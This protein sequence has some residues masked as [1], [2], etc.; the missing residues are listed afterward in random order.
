MPVN[1]VT[2]DNLTADQATRLLG[3]E[4]KP[5]A[6]MLLFVGTNAEGQQVPINNATASFI[7]TGSENLL[8]TCAHVVHGFR[9]KR[10]SDPEL[11]MAIGG[12]GQ[13]GVLEIKQEWLVDC[14][15]GTDLKIDLATYRLLDVGALAAFGKSCFVTS[16]WPP[17]KAREGELAVIA[18]FPGEH[19]Q[20]FERRMIAN[21]N[22]IADPITSV[23]ETYFTLAD[24]NQERTLVK[25]NESLGSLGPFGG[26]SGSA[27]YVVDSEGK[28][29]LVGFLHE[30]HD[31]V[32]ALIR[33]MHALLIR[34]DGK[35]ERSLIPF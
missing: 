18:G 24:E 29:R 2:M 19:R 13:T 34:E 23:R 20:Q 16:S 1:I 15:E 22:V 12:G 9:K 31:G 33:V 26:M 10:E 27:A 11:F 7:A 30:G 32:N 28:P 6:A 21:I 17:M 4:I 5:H 35:L 25:L 14:Y 8:V 3:D